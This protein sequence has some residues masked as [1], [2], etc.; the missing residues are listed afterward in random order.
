MSTLY[1]TQDDG[2]ETAVAVAKA[3]TVAKPCSIDYT[4]GEP[5]C[6]MCARP[7]GVEL[8]PSC[9]HAADPS[10]M[11][12]VV[13]MRRALEGMMR[14]SCVADAHPSDKDGEDHA[15]ESA[16]LRALSRI[17]EASGAG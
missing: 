5:R 11:G 15:A 1:I 3:G 6:I 13:E 4:R 2:T 14:H 7:G 12:A 10:L 17:R 9:P 16:A 8:M